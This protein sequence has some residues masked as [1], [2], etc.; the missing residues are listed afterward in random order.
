MTAANERAEPVVH[1]GQRVL[2]SGKP[3]FIAA[4]VG[5]NHNGDMA[6]A[7]RSIEAAKAAG[8]DA[9]KF[10]NYRTEDFLSD[11]TLTYAYVSQGKEV[12]EPQWD[13]FKRCELTTAMLREL[14]EHCDKVGLT[15]FSTPTSEQGVRELVE[16]G[17]PLLKNG[18]DFL[19]N[20]PLV[21]VMAR[22]GLLTVL[23]TGMATLAEV[24]DS[25]R[26]FNEAGGKE[27]M[28]LVCTSAY[29]TPAPAVHL[30]R[31]G[32]MKSAFGV[33]V[34]F[35]DHTEGIVAAVGAVTLG[36]CF[37]EK[38]FTLDKN[39]PGPDHRFSADPGELRALVDAVRFVETALGEPTLGPTSAEGEARSGYTLS[40]VAARAL[41][42]GHVLGESDIAL[43]RP[44]G[45]LPPRMLPMIIGLPLARAV[46]Q[47]HSFAM[48][49]FASAGGARPA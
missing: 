34:G 5:I 24:D 45:G 7:K 1:V 2:G 3:C 29:P 26:V 42:A 36:A 11:R 20:H 27:L 13:M 21:R 25:V 12:V 17:S 6:L 49:D 8:A 35:S 14:R 16:L 33:P 38:H 15:F 37:V 4:E 23:S 41:P 40:C 31:I 9:V 28:L 10:Q 47:G 39:L 18:S 32:A 46:T 19:S 44:G 48:G 43:R 22:T 30:R